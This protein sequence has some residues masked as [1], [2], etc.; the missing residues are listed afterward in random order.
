MKTDDSMDGTKAKKVTLPPIDRETSKVSSKDE[1]RDSQNDEGK[2]KKQK[3]SVFDK[4]GQLERELI[5]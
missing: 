5:L 4:N 3:T 2:P 1:T